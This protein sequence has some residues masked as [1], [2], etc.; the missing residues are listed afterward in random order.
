[1]RRLFTNGMRE[2]G[3]IPDQVITKTQKWYLM[4]PCLA[5]SIIR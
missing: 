5:L 4:Q 2:W 1:M 3:S